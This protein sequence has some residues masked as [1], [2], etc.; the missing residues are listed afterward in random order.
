[1]HVQDVLEITPTNGQLPA[2]MIIAAYRASQYGV[3]VFILSDTTPAAINA[4][5]DPVVGTM[6]L[7]IPGVIYIHVSDELRVSQAVN[8]TEAVYFATEAFRNLA[9]GYGAAPGNIRSICSS[10]FALSSVCIG[11]AFPPNESS[12]S[13]HQS[14]SRLPKMVTRQRNHVRMPPQ[15]LRG[16]YKQL[17]EPPG[18]TE[19][20]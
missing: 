15:S 6:A 5:L 4:I 17:H 3:V 9:V 10:Q 1:M 13:E 18:L 16:S 7:S 2:A 12:A 8:S 20:V 11:E 19:N 14:L